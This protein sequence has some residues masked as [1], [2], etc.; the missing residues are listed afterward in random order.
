[1]NFAWALNSTHTLDVATGVQTL[2]G[3]IANTTTPATFYYTYGRWNDSTSQ[4]HTITI[5]PEVL[6]AGDN[7]QKGQNSDNRWNSDVHDKRASS[8]GIALNV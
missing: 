4:S 3:D 6:S 5:T 1:M 7:F 8:V 2:T